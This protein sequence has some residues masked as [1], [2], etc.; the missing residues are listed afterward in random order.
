MKNWIRSVA[1]LLRRAGRSPWRNAPVGP[2]PLRVAAPPVGL[3]EELEARALLAVN[4]LNPFP[5]QTAQTNASPI[6]L[7]LT[8]RFDDPNLTGTIVR[9]NTPLGQIYVELFDQAGPGRS[10][11]TPLTAA[12]FLQYVDSGRYTNTL[13]HRSVPNFIIQGGGFV[14][15][16]F[17]GVAPSNLPAYG[18][19]QN[20]PGN[21]NVAGTIALAKIGGQPSSGTSQWFFNLGNN[22]S[23]LDNQ[24]GGFT[25]FGRIV[26]SGLSVAQQIAALDRVSDW[27]YFLNKG[28]DNFAYTVQPFPDDGV[29][30]SLPIRNQ[31]PDN[32]VNVAPGDF[33]SVGITRSTELTYTVTSS[34][35]G[36]VTGSIN[37]NQLT[38]NP[39]ANQAGTATITVRAT[40]V[41]GE[42]V[43][44]SFVIS[45][46]QA[47]TLAGLTL[48]S[49]T[50]TRPASVAA[51]VSGAADADGSIVRVE[52]FRDSDNNGVF[53][54]DTDQLLGTSTTGPTFISGVST[55]SFPGGIARLFARAIDN[56]GLI[57]APVTVTLNVVAPRPS[58]GTLSL[59]PTIVTSSGTFTLNVRNALGSDSELARIDFYRDSNRNGLF[60]TQDAKLGE[61][62]EPDGGVYSFDVA[63]NN[64]PGGSVRFFAIAIDTTG[65]ASQPATATG[66][67]QAS[68]PAIG[69]FTLAASTVQ[70][71]TPFA[72]DAGTVT[73]VGGIA[74]VQFYRDLNNNGAI[75]LTDTLLGED[76]TPGN[77]FTFSFATTG[78]EPGATVRFLARAQGL[79]GLFSPVVSVTGAIGR[80]P[81]ITG[82]TLPTS[83]VQR[84]GNATAT[85]NGV[86]DPDGTVA[87]VRFYR[88]VNNNG[89]LDVGTD[90]L[91]GTDTDPAGGWSLT[92]ATTGFGVGNSRIFAVAVDNQGIT[93]NPVNGNF[94]VQNQR[95]QPGTLSVSPNP[96]TRAGNITITLTG[97]RDPDGT[98]ARA[99]FYLDTNRSGVFDQGDEALAIDQDGSNGWSVSGASAG[100]P[101]GQV[102]I[103]AAVVDN[104]GLASLTTSVV[105]QASEVV[106]TAGTLNV[107]PVILP[108]GNFTLSLSGFTTEATLTRAQFYR[109]SN[110]NGNFDAGVDALVGEDTN[111]SGGWAVTAP[112]GVPS[113]TVRFFARV[114]DNDN[115][116]S[117]V[118]TATGNVSAVPTVS[119]LTASPTTATRPAPIVLTI[120][121][122]A[123]GSGTIASAQFYRDSNNNGTFDA[124]TD[125]LLGTD[126]TPGNG[127]TFSVETSGLG[128][129]PVRFFARVTN[130]LGQT[131]ATITTTATVR[132]ALP[133]V[134]AL[135]PSAASVNRAQSLVL[136]AS[137]VADADGTINLVRFYRD[138]NNNGAFDS[139]DTLLGNGTLGVPGAY[140]Y[141]V[142]LASIP[143]GTVRF[144][145]VPVDNE[146][147]TGAA[148]TTRVT[149]QNT[150]PTIGSFLSDPGSGPRSGPFTLRAL[151][152]AD[153]AGTIARVEFFRDSNN[154]GTFDAGSDVKLGNGTLT[155]GEYRLTLA[156]NTLALGSNRLFARA[157]DNESLSSTILLLDL[158]TT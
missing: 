65:T 113:G 111:A 22:A 57:S 140:T 38:L 32:L 137:G 126:S 49:F 138:S 20:E 107:T 61:S 85:A 62:T 16:S 69:T 122:A 71:G 81:T 7:S 6:V 97:A 124:A 21:T 51:S 112:A 83:P 23:N 105:F 134:A 59:A 135:T 54:P 102:R 149:I 88:D 42:F 13:I 56:T 147:Q 123:P 11:T 75:D 87:E 35:S 68:A 1:W 8:S 52:Y 53:N 156:G 3:L 158:V 80:P 139:A 15:P 96:Y 33:V 104:D 127:L 129:G 25:A 70:A 143:S 73:P 108:G 12:N 26:G 145:A 131:S 55:A 99:E 100:I 36:L 101:S 115:R 116:T 63:A 142:N 114:T 9:F 41:T 92:F 47:P 48:S 5:D 31:N 152:V 45:I 46:G 146:G 153:S 66:T 125:T 98:V 78:L 91:L 14:T 150:A 151:N 4:V 30:P 119:S 60:D 77:G 58:A 128:A 155:S 50:V 136:T 106:L 37:N 154:N 109:D 29:D 132:G 19:V 144:F 64:L 17:T 76:T 18:A 67:V 120:N 74:R 90:T 86:A 72:L 40:S 44:D 89:T 82:L 39:V 130:S 103:F 148:A 94:A 10:R 34:N 117:P 95:P 24:N 157:T 93:S 118:I 2:R 43:E 121:G 28:N 110:N 133:T 84:P 27:E 141:S 79:S